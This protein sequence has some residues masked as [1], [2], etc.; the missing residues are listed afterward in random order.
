MVLTDA[1]IIM[2]GYEGRCDTSLFEACDD[3]V[4]SVVSETVVDVR[5]ASQ[6]IGCSGDA[7]AE[8]VGLGNSG[9]LIKIYKL[10]LICKIG[11]TELE[12]EQNGTSNA[13][14]TISDECK[15]LVSLASC[16]RI[17]I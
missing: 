10:R 6:G 1:S 5:C 9:N 14:F 4:G 8:T 7:N 11:R 17:E 13:G 12:E 15:I 2:F 3:V 16:C